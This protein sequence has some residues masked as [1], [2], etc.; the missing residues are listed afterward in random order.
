MLYVFHFWLSLS[1]NVLSPLKSLL[2][3]AKKTS[4]TPT[5]AIS[6]KIRKLLKWLKVVVFFLPSEN[7][8]QRKKGIFFSELYQARKKMKL[9][10]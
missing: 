9:R 6:G 8:G 2:C 5:K 1:K 3:K 4:F 7:T 10:G